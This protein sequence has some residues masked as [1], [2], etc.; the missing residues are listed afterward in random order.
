M[1][2]EEFIKTTNQQYARNF[3]DFAT[4]GK[5]INS[6]DNILEVIPRVHEF[7]H[8]LLGALGAPDNNYNFV[9][10]LIIPLEVGLMHSL[11]LADRYLDDYFITPKVRCL[12][13]RSYN[14]VFI[15]DKFGKK[16]KYPG[17][18]YVEQEGVNIKYLYSHVATDLM[19]ALTDDFIKQLIDLG[20]E[21]GDL[22]KI[23]K[24]LQMEK[25]E[26]RTE[27]DPWFHPSICDK[28]EDTQTLNRN[29]QRF[30]QMLET[31]E[32]QELYDMF[33]GLLAQH[34]ELME[35]L[36]RLLAIFMHVVF[37]YPV[38]FCMQHMKVAGEFPDEFRFW[39]HQEDKV[40]FRVEK[41]FQLIAKY[42]QS[43]S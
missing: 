9:E 20:M 8:S 7:A 29:E 25:L 43:V 12:D 41:G 19:R 38:E 32:I 27:E 35:N 4:A 39:N 10:Y 13:V 14:I 40:T 24:N 21:M 6:E 31:T 1:N 33:T 30:K 26:G 42:F 5:P 28:L 23:T 17:A 34:P 16:R 37:A 18:K 11:D 15:F 36:K 3:T 2:V 22:L